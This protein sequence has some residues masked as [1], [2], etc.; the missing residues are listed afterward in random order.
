MATRKSI[1]GDD[2]QQNEQL[3]HNRISRVIIEAGNSAF[4]LTSFVLVLITASILFMELVHLA[5]LEALVVATFVGFFLCGW[6]I[7]LAFTIRQVSAARTAVAV[8]ET[9]RTRATAESSVV[10]A[11]DHYIVWREPDGSYQFRGSTIITENRQFLPREIGAC[12]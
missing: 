11:T 1:Q 10:H 8:D 2:N 4:L 9:L 6:I 7:L 3:S 5:L 12:G